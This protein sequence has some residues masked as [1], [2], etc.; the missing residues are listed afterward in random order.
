[1]EK[2]EQASFDAGPLIH[3]SEISQLSL[4]RLIDEKIISEEVYKEY[5]KHGK[6]DL[7][8]EISFFKFDSD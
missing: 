6:E 4:L 5:K 7:E 3:L 2:I 1:M 8:V